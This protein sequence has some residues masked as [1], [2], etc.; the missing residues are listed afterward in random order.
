MQL[1]KVERLLLANQYLI[2]S[3]LDPQ[4]ESH[5]RMV[6]ALEHG[7][8]AAIQEALSKR[9]FDG[10]PE[11]ECHVV[12]DALELYGTIQRSYDALED[13]AGIEEHRVEFSGFDGNHETAHMAYAKYL[14]EK[15]GR[16]PYLRLA[17]GWA[18]SHTEM[19]GRYRRQI[20][21][22]KSMDE[23]RELTREDIASIL[24]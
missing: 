6:K 17:R 13:K 24:G 15:E 20:A 19:L 14:L 23:K 16:Y 10:L 4:D 12:Q 1:T 11:E 2:L 7:Y 21:V 8:E 9:I 5:T 3:K 22:W 18:N